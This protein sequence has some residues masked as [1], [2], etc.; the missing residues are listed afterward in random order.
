MSPLQNR[1]HEIIFEAETPAGKTFDVAL[2]VL[3]ALSVV[4]VALETVQGQPD[5]LYRL[6]YYLEWGLTILF[7]LEYLL[8]IYTIKSSWKY[9]SS[10]YGIVDLLSILPTYL[11]LFVAGSQ[12]LLTIRA[13]R[14]LRVFRIMKLGSYLAE[15]HILISAIQASRLKITVFLGTVL[16]VV[17]IIGSAMYLIESG[18]DSGFTSIPKSIY[19]AIVTITTVG[20]GDIAPATPLGQFLSAILMIMGYG[21]IAV[22]TGIVSVEI[23]Q[24][25]E[26]A[27]NSGNT[28]SC[29]NCA[30]EGHDQDATYCKFCGHL[31]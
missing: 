16:T 13:L 27:K 30:K 21:V 2:L 22:P 8:R 4:V 29:P 31:L 11:S 7:T 28:I 10:F 24:A 23:A 18:A 17:V 26:K 1:I 6:Y 14:F 12:Y 19:W 15:S 3:I 25:T 5:A 20:Y 9:I